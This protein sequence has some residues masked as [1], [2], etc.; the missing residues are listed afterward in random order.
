MDIKKVKVGD[1]VYISK[2]A[3]ESWHSQKEFSEIYLT[4][5]RKY[6]VL[7]IVNTDW[8]FSST[9]KVKDDLN[10]EVV[11]P[12]YCFNLALDEEKEFFKKKPSGIEGKTNL[13]K[14]P[15]LCYFD[16]NLEYEMGMGMRAGA[17]KHGWN[18][19]RNL[20]SD[21]AQQILDSLKRHINAFLRGE[22][23]DAETETSHLACA[24]NNLNFL[25]RMTKEDGF[26]KVI[27]NIYG[28]KENI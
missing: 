3:L 10:K 12:M 7:Q 9:I 27:E 25:Y 1:Y 18:N 8:V 26:E 20:K 2:L 19:H 13:N 11:Y 15:H 28:K 22:E 5:D 6:K 16:P 14:K 21:S 24:I 4:E 17:L 23:N